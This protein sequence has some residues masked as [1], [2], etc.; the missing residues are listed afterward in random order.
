MLTQLEQIIYES[1]KVHR[2]PAAVAS[3]LEMEKTTVNSILQSIARK[4]ENVAVSNQPTKTTTGVRVTNAS[5]VRDQIR[6][7]KA[8]FSKDEVEEAV[9]DWCMEVLGQS[10]QLAKTY[11]HN[12]WDKV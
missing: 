11:F 9:I 12:N 5:L 8:I 10:K 6:D 4:G 7:L 1:Y 2:T 3:D